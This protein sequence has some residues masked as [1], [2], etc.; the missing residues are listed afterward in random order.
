MPE[1]V[2]RAFCAAV[3]EAALSHTGVTH[4]GLREAIAEIRSGQPS[5]SRREAVGGIVHQLDV[6]AWDLAAD[7]GGEAYSVA[8]RRAR[9]AAAIE[10]ACGEPAGT[11]EGAAY[12]AHH[13][14]LTLAEIEQL[15]V[16]R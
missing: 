5:T 7:G 13:A 9:A 3:C 1:P 6:V 8:F 15:T 10:E 11:A 4:P 2:R 14:G 12:E 16:D